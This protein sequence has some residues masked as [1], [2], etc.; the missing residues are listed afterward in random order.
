MD[1]RGQ[2]NLRKIKT[3]QQIVKRKKQ[4]RNDVAF[5]MCMPEYFK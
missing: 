4:H 2:M 5:F 3:I 1:D